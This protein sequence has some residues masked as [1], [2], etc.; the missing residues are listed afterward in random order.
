MGCGWLL[1]SRQLREREVV[2]VRDWMRVRG[3]GDMSYF[4]WISPSAERL[5]HLPVSRRSGISLQLAMSSPRYWWYV[6]LIFYSILFLVD[7]SILP[8]PL[9][10]D[11]SFGPGAYLAWLYHDAQPNHQEC[12]RNYSSKKTIFPPDHG[13]SFSIRLSG[14]QPPHPYHRPLNFERLTVMR[15]L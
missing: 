11:C 1:Y 14:R 3:T 6:F 4:R 10:P 2:C 13:R 15:S 9:E 5:D 8:F 12:T 7:G